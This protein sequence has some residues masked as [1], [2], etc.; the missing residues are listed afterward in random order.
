MCRESAARRL[1]RARRVLSLNRSRKDEV[2][3]RR[4]SKPLRFFAHSLTSGARGLE[5]AS[6]RRTWAALFRPNERPAELRSSHR[7]ILFCRQ[8]TSLLRC[9]SAAHCFTGVGDPCLLLAPTTAAKQRRTAETCP[10]GDADALARPERG[11][12]SVSFFGESARDYSIDLRNSLIRLAPRRA[13]S[14]DP[15]R[16]CRSCCALAR[17]P[18]RSGSR[19]APREIVPSVACKEASYAP[20]RDDRFCIQPRKARTKLIAGLTCLD[21]VGDVYDFDDYSRTADGSP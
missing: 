12:L 5:Y 6:L 1:G 4:S 9:L 7:E 3:R 16:G 19:V 8:R 21:S 13:I 17:T 2:G 18:R 15:K 20:A 11:S 10:E 14:S